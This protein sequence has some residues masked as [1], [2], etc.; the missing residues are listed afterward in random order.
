MAAAEAPFIWYEAHPGPVH[1]GLGGI[2]I[3][4]AVE[5][6]IVGSPRRYVVEPADAGLRVRRLGPDGA[7]AWATAVPAVG[8]GAPVLFYSISEGVFVAAPI[9]DRYLV[10]RVDMESGALLSRAE[11]PPLDGT[12]P[13]RIQLGQHRE[14]LAVYLRR[15]SSAA[16]D[17]V[18]M[19]GG[20]LVGRAV[21]AAG[22]VGRPRPTATPGRPRTRGPHPALDGG[23]YTTA[24]AV[25][26]PGSE[27]AKRV[28]G[29][30][31]SG[32]FPNGQEREKTRR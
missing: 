15:D 31:D 18:A 9:D 4:T 26:E 25:P 29:V 22:D 11:G 32:A 6:P 23:R 1:G 28:S 20:A 5:V 12:G 8:A 2:G 10:A 24:R 21:V 17:V 14:H 27:T 19:D 3:S 13:L 16:V 30:C 7:E